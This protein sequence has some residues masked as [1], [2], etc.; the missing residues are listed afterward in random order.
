LKRTEEMPI[1]PKLDGKRRWDL[2]TV[3]TRQEL[4]DLVRVG[5]GGRGKCCVD[6]WRRM[7]T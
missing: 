7:M 6:G 2:S 5:E 3:L 4:R 1:H